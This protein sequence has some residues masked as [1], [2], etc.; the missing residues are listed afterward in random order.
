MMFPGMAVPGRPAASRPAASALPVG[1]IDNAAA[2]LVSR[3]EWA[4]PRLETK[5]FASM[6]SKSQLM[7]FCQK[8]LGSIF[9]GGDIVYTNNKFPMGF[10]SI[11]KLVCLGGQEF[12]GELKPSAT[13]AEQAAAQQA[14][15]SFK[16]EISALG[17]DRG[18]EV[19]RKRKG[20]P[21]EPSVKI[22]KQKLPPGILGETAVVP[23][24]A[25]A[26]VQTSKMELNTHCSKIVRRVMEKTDV[27]YETDDV[28][29][30]G[31][32]SKLRLSCLPDS[33]GSKVFV[34]EVN[35]KKGDAEQSV[36]AVALAAIRTDVSLMSKFAAP[37]K[38][39][40]R[41][42]GMKGK[43]GGKG[44]VPPPNANMLQLQASAFMAPQM[45]VLGLG[46]PQSGFW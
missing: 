3:P 13:E 17:L 1:R 14:V 25:T 42:P 41:P 22:K 16:A 26:I 39:K 27:T 2:V 18:V 4:P 15:E 46:I 12:A 10:Q 29:G 37:P 24:E 19:T 8:K 23:P 43:G 45:Q 28:E 38:Q 5:D 7:H 36:A 40:V 33:W 35:V 9:K 30:G 44:K 20:G 21:M 6:D 34:G 31:Y 32:Q 11:V